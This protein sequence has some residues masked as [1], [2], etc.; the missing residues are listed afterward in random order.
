[1]SQHFSPKQVSN[2]LVFSM[3]PANLKCFRGIGGTNVADALTPAYGYGSYSATGFSAYGEAVSVNIPKL[4]KRNAVAV[5]IN[6]NY[7]LSGACCPNLFLYYSGFLP[8]SAS[9]TYTYAIVYKTNTGYTSPNFMYRYEFT[10][11]N[12]ANYV[13]EGG[14]HN[15]SNRISLGD[16][17]WY[18]WGQFTT[19][20]TST[21]ALFYLFYYQYST[22]D[23][24]YVADVSVTQGSYIH[25]PRFLIPRGTTRLDTPAG[26]GGV[27]DLTKNGRD[28]ILYNSP[29]FSSDG[30]GS[31]IFDGVNDYIEVS[32]VPDLSTTNKFTVMIWGKSAASTW[33]ENGWLMSRRD[34]FLIHPNSTLTSVNMYVYTSGYYAGTVYPSDITQWNHYALTFNAGSCTM[35]LNGAN[36]GTFSSGATLSSDTGVVAIGRDDGLSR[37]G[38]GR[39]SNAMIYNRDLSATEILQNY[40]ATKARFGR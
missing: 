10:A 24:V 34:Q 14:V 27:L 9:T 19:A 39:A 1:M 31:V 11:A 3:D 17:W 8:I 15:D 6:N 30:G 23:V 35:Y 2:G 5:Y 18:A 22:D 13:T 26:G 36:A 4:G 40:N 29:T 20:A 32:N 37:Y 38:S 28:G 33:N 21:Y 12:W 16:G 7:S 25:D